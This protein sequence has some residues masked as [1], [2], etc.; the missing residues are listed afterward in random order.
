MFKLECVRC[1]RDKEI[2][3]Q[4]CDRCREYLLKLPAPRSGF[5][6]MG[7]GFALQEVWGKTYPVNSREEAACAS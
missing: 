5:G 6:P 3:S 4:F 2:S 7:A 1:G